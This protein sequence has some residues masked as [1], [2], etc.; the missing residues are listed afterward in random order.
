MINALPQDVIFPLDIAE[1]FFNN[2]SPYAWEFLISQ[3]V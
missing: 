3:G 1:H 2:S